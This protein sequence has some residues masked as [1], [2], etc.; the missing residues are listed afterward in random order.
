[1]NGP[2]K[3]VKPSNEIPHAN[4][5]N[6]R[7][8]LDRPRARRDAAKML[9]VAIGIRYR[10]FL[11]TSGDQ[12]ANA[13]A[14]AEL[15]QCLYENIEFIEWALKHI[16][17]LNPRPPEELRRISPAA[18]SNSLPKM[19]SALA[20][21]AA[22]AEAFADLAMERTGGEGVK[23]AALDLPCTC[24]PLEHGIIGRDRHMTSCPLYR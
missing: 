3:T 6:Q 15:A 20:L 21:D 13:L 12:D 11:E 1:M 18:N 2:D 7:K 5:T 10:R 16:G 14:T 17:G 23:S 19:P 4:G 22:K 9:G 8:T 24:P